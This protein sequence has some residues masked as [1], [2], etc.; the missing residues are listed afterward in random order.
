MPK[1]E[2]CCYSAECA[3]T[4]E[5]AGADRIELC[6][7][8]KEGGLTPGFGTLQAVRDRVALPVHPIIRPRGGDFCYSAAEFEVM[9]NDVEQ[10]RDMGFPGLVIGLLDA[11]GHV[12]LAR[13]RR[14]MHLAGTM[15]VTFHRAFEICASILIRRCGN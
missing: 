2:V 10:V 1:L 6:C 8:P 3:I 13:M 5:Q 9:L 12:D 15:A 14:I 4:A 11:D 7:A